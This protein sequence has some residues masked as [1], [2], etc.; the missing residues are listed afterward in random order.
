MKAHLGQ[1]LSH[2]HLEDI[3]VI[4]QVFLVE[5]KA[6]VSRFEPAFE[7]F[8]LKIVGRERVMAGFG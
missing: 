7:L 3:L 2:W 8:P 1:P 5:L 6:W 4:H